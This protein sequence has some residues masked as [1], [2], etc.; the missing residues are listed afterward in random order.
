MCNLA[1]AFSVR[2]ITACIYVYTAYMYVYNRYTGMAIFIRNM[3]YAAAVPSNAIVKLARCA[4]VMMT[5]V[6]ARSIVRA[7]AFLQLQHATYISYVSYV[8]T[9]YIVHNI[10]NRTCT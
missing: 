10:L 8:H 4:R 6:S 5:D 7:P 3:M 9:I 1:D 2:F